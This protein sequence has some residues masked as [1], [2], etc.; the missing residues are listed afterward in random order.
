[1]GYMRHHAIVVTSWKT[2]LLQAA[3][4]K[5]TELGCTVTN[6][7][8]EVVNGYQSFLVAPDGSKEG[9]GGSDLGDK[10]RAELVEWLDQQRYDDGSTS[11]KW[12]LVQFGDE[13]GCNGIILTDELQ[14]RR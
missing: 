14:G 13:D 11:L 9:W 8:D 7:T 1:M 6:V 3:H 12:A 5:A 10:Q 4:A 2:E